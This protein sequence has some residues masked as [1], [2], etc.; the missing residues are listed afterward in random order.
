MKPIEISSAVYGRRMRLEN[1]GRRDVRDI[2]ITEKCNVK[3]ILFASI[4]YPVN[5]RVRV[6][7]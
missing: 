7:G 1:W 2:S 3:K 4:L 5:M 6:R